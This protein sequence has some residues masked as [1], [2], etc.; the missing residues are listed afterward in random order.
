[1]IDFNNA[2]FS[3]HRE[4]AKGNYG[5]TIGRMLTENEK[6]T[7][8][9]SCDK[10]S[11]VFTDK[12]L[13]IIQ[14]CGEEKKDFTSLSYSKIQTYSVDAHKHNEQHINLELWFSGL[15]VVKVN[16]GRDKKA[17]DIYRMISDYVL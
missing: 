16:F 7:F 8:S 11:L 2:S 5:E 10:G 4:E 9:Y 14:D 17:Y 1:M 6:V 13:F 12:R 3:I 15:G